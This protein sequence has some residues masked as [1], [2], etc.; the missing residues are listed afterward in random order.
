MMEACHPVMGRS[1]QKYASDPK[2]VCRLSSW[3]RNVPYPTTQRSVRLRETPVD[4]VAK[5]RL[6]IRS[7]AWI[8]WSVPRCSTEK[9][10]DRVGVLRGWRGSVARTSW[11]WRVAR[12]RS[13]HGW[14]W[15]RDARA[16]ASCESWHTEARSPRRTE[17]GRKVEAS[18]ARSLRGVRSCACDARFGVCGS[19]GVFPV[20]PSE[21][22]PTNT[23]D[24]KKKNSER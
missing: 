16:A 2:I 12:R 20:L 23:K 7:T 13:R 17:E 15:V 11:E 6:W 3:I 14:N 1:H 18:R 19:P 4:G 5:L 21:V 10:V 9:K 22:S 8:P 24:I